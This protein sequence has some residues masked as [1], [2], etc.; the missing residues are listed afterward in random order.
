[1]AH[2]FSSVELC[3]PSLRTPRSPQDR[4]VRL[5][6]PVEE[7]ATGAAAA[8]RVEGDDKRAG[9][10]FR[11]ACPKG[12]TRAHGAELKVYGFFSFAHGNLRDCPVLS[13]LLV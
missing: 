2:P 10:T 13:A 8:V 4:G 12:A 3:T 9:N 11:S 5:S 7:E 1:M 6:H